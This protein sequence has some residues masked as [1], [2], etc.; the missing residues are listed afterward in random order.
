MFL[1]CTRSFYPPSFSS[2]HHGMVTPPLRAFS[3]QFGH[4]FPD[5]VFSHASPVVQF[6][7]GSVAVHW[8]DGRAETIDTA[9]SVSGTLADTTI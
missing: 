6:Q 8:A 9:H 3:G 2:S 1:Y 5:I 7:D 4:L